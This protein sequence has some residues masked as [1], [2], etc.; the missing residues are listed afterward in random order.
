MSLINDALKRAKQAQPPAAPSHTTQFH[1]RPV[2]HNQ[3][4]R[5]GF[6]V[7]MPV[8]FALVALLVLFLVWQLAQQN[9]ANRQAA[10][11]QRSELIARA[12]SPTTIAPPVPAAVPATPAPSAAEP[13]TPAPGVNEQ[14]TAPAPSE[15]ATATTPAVADATPPV[16]EAPPVP[17]KPTLRLQSIVFNPARPSAMIN[18]KILFVGDKVGD[19]HISAITQ[20]SA[21]LFNSSQT[22]TLEL[23]E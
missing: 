9:I 14:P 17:P 15:P 18:G 5:H 7:M 21:T 23:G 22:N 12:A 1:F 10:T 16:P 11:A 3:T 8:A 2:D 19:Y 13:T 4:A 6:G 20:T